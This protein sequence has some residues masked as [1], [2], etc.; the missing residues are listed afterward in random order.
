MHNQPNGPDTKPKPLLKMVQA[1]T[2]DSSSEAL[3]RLSDLMPIL[4][5][6]DE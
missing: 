4:I 6:C 3:V 5:I 2:C 1:R